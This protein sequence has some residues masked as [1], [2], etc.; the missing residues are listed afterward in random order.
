MFA[1][2]FELHIVSIAD[3]QSVLVLIVKDEVTARYFDNI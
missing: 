3:W 2:L 1:R